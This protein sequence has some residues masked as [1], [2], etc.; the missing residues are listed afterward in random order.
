MNG[1][2]LINESVD[3]FLALAGNFLLLKR[4]PDSAVDPGK[5]NGIGGRVHLGE[6][7]LEAAVRKIREETGYGLTGEDLHFSGLAREEGCS[8][9]DW[10]IAYYFATVH[11]EVPPLGWRTPAGELEWVPADKVLTKDVLPD[12]PAIFPEVIK[13]DSGV[14]FAHWQYM[15]NQPPVIKIQR[16]K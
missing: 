5:Y 10:L 16:S 4:L 8:N 13:P 12:L 6:T 11:E 7:Y 3:V 2:R 1:A 14:F 15:P 9:G